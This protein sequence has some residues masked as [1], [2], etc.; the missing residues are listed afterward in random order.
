MGF[1]TSLFHTVTSKA[2]KTP[3]NQTRCPQT[4]TAAAATAADT[5]STLRVS[6][7]RPASARGSEADTDTAEKKWTG[8]TNGGGG[9]SRGG[10]WYLQRDTRGPQ[11]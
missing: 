6:V 1:H 10:V 7:H 3:V 11:A 8:N 5:K 2:D 9:V 4:R